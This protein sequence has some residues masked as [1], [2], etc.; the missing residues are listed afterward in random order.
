MSQGNELAQRERDSIQALACSIL[1]N[2][3]TGL[4]GS[5]GRWEFQLIFSDQPPE[6]DIAAIGLPICQANAISD[7]VPAP[8]AIEM[9]ASAHCATSVFE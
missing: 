4:S 7:R 6:F 8:P 3:A 5:D 1:S 2:L 9:Q